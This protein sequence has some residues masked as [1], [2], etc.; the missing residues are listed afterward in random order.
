VLELTL[1]WNTGLTGKALSIAQTAASPLRV[2]AGPGTGKSF[3]IMRRVARLLEE[4]TGPE[5]LLAV[6]FTRTAA[7]D[8]RR[9]LSRLGVPGSDKVDAGTLHAFCFR[10]LQQASVLAQTHRHPRP[11]VTF[12]EK[13]VMQFEAKPM[14]CDLDARYGDQRQKSKRVLAF[15][16]AW[17]RLQWNTPGFVV[18]PLDQEF[19][20]DLIE[21]LRYQEAMVLGELI[22][23]TLA[24]LRANPTVPVLSAYDHVV[25]DEYQD[26]NRAEQDLIDLLA[27]A[28]SLSIVGDE[29]QSIYRFRHA[30]PDGIREFHT[31]HASTHD[32][33]LDECRRCP[34]LVVSMA[35]HLIRR[36]HPAG[37]PPRL[38]PMAARPAGEVHIVQWDDLPAEIAGLAAYVKELTQVRSVAPADIL[39]LSPRKYVGYG[40]R[41]A[42]VAH[43][44]PA[45]SFYN[46]E[47]LDDA[48]AQHA[49]TLLT[50]VA[51]PSDRVAYR[52]WLGFGSNDWRR[53]QY[54]TLRAAATA[55][56][57]PP[58]ELL[59]P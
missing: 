11:L 20:D 10:T 55:A 24:Y 53:G 32:E 42:M 4:G 46:E 12:S 16:A 1:S 41:D 26:L 47:A 14:L 54:A 52:C 2:L 43:G 6:T 50:L 19:H 18:Q 34:Q 15:E 39:I 33:T 58:R 44:I 3:A 56:N 25:V 59:V 37:T 9:E 13:G 48:E 22:P 35:D 28:G 8:L 49:F 7:A 31:T 51:N 17:A 27:S 23:Q 29:D 40:L 21:W 36:N 38:V 5:R 45:H 30:N 57:R